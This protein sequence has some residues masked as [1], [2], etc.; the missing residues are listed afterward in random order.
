MVSLDYN[1][2]THPF[3]KEDDFNFT[4]N[5]FKSVFFI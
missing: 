2:L 3:L 1:E 4:Y 5:N